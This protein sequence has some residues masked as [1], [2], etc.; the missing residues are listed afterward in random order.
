MLCIQLSFQ[1]V[2]F[3]ISS[4]INKYI[5]KHYKIAILKGSSKVS[6]YTELS[7]A[8]II[9]ILEVLVHNVFYNKC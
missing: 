4:Q 9:I 5:K 3:F 7:L 8:C 6:G 1:V 2:W